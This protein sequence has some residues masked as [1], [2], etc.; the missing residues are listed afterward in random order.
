MAVH[1]LLLICVEKYSLRNQI[2]QREWEGVSE[3]N[4]E[5]ESEEQEED[6]EKKCSK[7][8]SQKSK[9]TVFEPLLQYA[10]QKSR[11]FSL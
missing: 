7:Y 6:Y 10:V 4:I 2:V 9:I 1:Q 5:R 3:Q 11:L 8:R